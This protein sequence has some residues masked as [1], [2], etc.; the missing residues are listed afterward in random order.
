MQILVRRQLLTSAGI[1]EYRAIQGIKVDLSLGS[2]DAT[3]VAVNFGVPAD[4]HQTTHAAFI[5]NHHRRVVFHRITVNGIGK[6]SAHPQ[7]LAKKEIQDVYAVRGNV[8]KR[9]R[10]S[11]RL[12]S[13]HT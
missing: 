5:I 7:G 9:D 6:V 1:N 3:F 10:K 13:S 4:V 11:T 2:P 12:N 8:V